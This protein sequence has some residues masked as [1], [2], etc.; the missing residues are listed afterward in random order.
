M[1]AE[2][3][4]TVTQDP[5]PTILADHT[6]IEQLFQNLIGNA[7]KYRSQALPRIHVAAEEIDGGWRLTIT[8]NGIGIDMAYADR[9]F[10]VF[11]RLHPR[12]QYEGTGIGLAVCKRIVES[13]GGRIGVDSIPGEGSTFWFTL[14]V[15]QHQP[16]PAGGPRCGHSTGLMAACA[17]STRSRC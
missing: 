3:R 16:E 15:E 11:R 12:G 2:A 5:L 8:D 1:L 17:V 7:L 10:H 13:Y 14:P 9:I 6:P 4:A